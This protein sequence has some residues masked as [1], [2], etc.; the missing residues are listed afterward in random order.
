MH[1]HYIYSIIQ[2]C[3]PDGLYRQAL[4]TS[5]SDA[6][7][8]RQ[9][10]A[11]RSSSQMGQRRTL[12]RCGCSPRR[13]CIRQLARVGLLS[14]LPLTYTHTITHSLS[15]NLQGN[16]VMGLQSAAGVFSPCLGATVPILNSQDSP[17]RYHACFAANTIVAPTI[18]VGDIAIAHL[19]Q[20]LYFTYPSPFGR[21]S[22]H[23]L[24]QAG[25]TNQRSHRLSEC[26]Q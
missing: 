2:P 1:N 17:G 20:V 3:S 13:R 9:Q 19:L 26:K 15:S 24:V 5:K 7:W 6:R 10:T 22:P 14:P 25:V 11:S 23:T 21:L 16:P 18:S 4:P 12:S 8:A